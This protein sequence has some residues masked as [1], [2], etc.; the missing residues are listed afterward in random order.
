MF[1]MYYIIDESIHMTF[2]IQTLYPENNGKY[3]RHESPAPIL[4]G[5]VSTEF[6]VG[7]L[8]NP[9]NSKDRVKVPKYTK[10]SLWSSVTKSKSIR[11]QFVES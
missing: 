5:F 8:Q 11:S 3:Q 4:S 10:T 6:M 2:Q 7:F 1:K 9:R